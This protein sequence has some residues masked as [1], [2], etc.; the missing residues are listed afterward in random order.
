MIKEL[1][2]EDVLNNIKEGESITIPGGKLHYIN[3]A[4][5][6]GEMFKSIKPI[7]EEKA[8]TYIKKH[9]IKENLN[10]F[11][12]KV[13]LNVEKLGKNCSL[14]KK[15]NWFVKYLKIGNTGYE[16]ILK[17]CNSKGI[18]FTTGY[19]VSGL[20]IRREMLSW[21]RKINFESKLKNT[22]LKVM[23]DFYPY[24]ITRDNDLIYMHNININFEELLHSEDNE[25][26]LV[27]LISD[28]IIKIF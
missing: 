21:E 28:I 1:K 18:S 24:T 8:Y 14:E 19:Y 3:G 5:C 12:Y 11:L 2:F 13:V 6:I 23:E 25:A 26:E 17:R 16:I 10:N 7:D 9:V 20:H 4:F 22:S 27:D 15:P